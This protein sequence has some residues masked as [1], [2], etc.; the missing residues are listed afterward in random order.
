MNKKLIKD[1]L[2]ETPD[3]TPTF[4]NRYA[5]PA[6]RTPNPPIDGIAAATHTSGIKIRK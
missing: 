6:S 5:V 2:T 3:S 1:M 4:A